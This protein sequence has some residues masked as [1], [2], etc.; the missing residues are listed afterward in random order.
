MAAECRNVVFSSTC[1]TYGDHDG[2]I[3][4]EDTPQQPINRLWRHENAPSG[5]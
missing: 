5:T 1:A 2:V 4:D 3:L